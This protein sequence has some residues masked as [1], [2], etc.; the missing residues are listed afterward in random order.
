MAQDM[1]T[2]TPREASSPL[3]DAITAIRAIQTG[4]GRLPAERPLA[5]RLGIKR[6]LLRQ[7]LAELRRG[8]D[9]P[10]P[11]KRGRGAD[12]AMRSLGF[13]RDSNPVEVIE[14][15]MMIEPALARL[16]S[17]RATPN[18]IA[19]MERM[20]EEIGRR[21]GGRRS[22]LDLHR[23]IAEASGNGLAR[24]FYSLLRD[25]DKEVRANAH[26]DGLQP[27]ADTAEHR[28]I[29]EAIAA[30]NPEAAEAAMRVHL[31]SIHRL[32]SPLFS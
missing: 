27:A 30:R 32:L 24:E 7:A 9:L 25:I 1:M 5:E 19:V 3:E 26:V 2:Q 14:M 13:G 16:A 23:M 15:R 29:V 11:P 12:P 22:T 21:G 18:Q 17:L 20:V 8:G 28:A 10:S 4:E 31:L 6:H